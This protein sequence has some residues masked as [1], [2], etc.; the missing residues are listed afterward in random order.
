MLVLIF[1]RRPEEFLKGGV[2]NVLQRI[3]FPIISF[4]SGMYV[5]RQK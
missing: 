2:F 5:F 3:P 4:R 1:G